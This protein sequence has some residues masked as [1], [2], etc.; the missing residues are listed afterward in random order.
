MAM[1]AILAALPSSTSCSSCTINVFP[2]RVRNTRGRRTGAV[3]ELSCR[4]GCVARETTAQIIQQCHRTHGG[5]IELHNCIADVI[6][7]A[8]KNKGWTVVQQPHVRTAVGLRKPDIIAYRNGVGVIVDA[9]VI[10]GQRDLDG[11]HR[12]KRNKYGNHDELVEKVAG[13]LGLPCKGSVH[14]TSCT[15]SW[16]GVWSLASYR[17][18][19][20]FVGLDEGVL[21]GVPSLVLRGSHMNWGRFNRHPSRLRWGARVR[22]SCDC[23]D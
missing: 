15:L 22:A 13:I 2:S 17:E 7:S 12:E 18:L 8:M 9:Q 23:K 1:D 16:R 19:K 5:R 20:R 4:A 14:S 6:S 3:L 10:S 21:A 11:L